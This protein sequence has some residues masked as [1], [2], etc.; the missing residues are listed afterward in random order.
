[1]WINTSSGRV[2][3][4]LLHLAGDVQSPEQHSRNPD[5]LVDRIAV[6]NQPVTGVLT[7]QPS[8]VGFKQAH[9]ERHC[10]RGSYLS[11]RRL[12]SEWMACPDSIRK[13]RNWQRLCGVGGTGHKEP[14]SSQS[15]WLSSKSV[16]SWLVL[17]QWRRVSCKCPSSLGVGDR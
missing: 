11:L 4:Q 3:L 15:V 6:H 12:R 5:C 13:P 9:H 8:L 1:M 10:R 14:T 7:K 2:Q 17:R 16:K